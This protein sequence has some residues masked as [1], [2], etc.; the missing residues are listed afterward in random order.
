MHSAVKAAVEAAKRTSESPQSR[1]QPLPDA[2]K[3][4]D[5]KAHKGR[6]A[7][8]EAILFVSREPVPPEQLMNYLQIADVSD[9]EKITDHLEK[10][11]ADDSRGISL[12]RS[13]GGL[14]LA[15]KP[16]M[17]ERLKDFF[18]TKSSSKL[19][20]PSLETLAIVAYRQPVTIAEISDLRGVNST[21]PV[22]KSAA[23]ETGAYH[24]S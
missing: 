7:L 22:K 1:R 12:Q 19:T 3:P 11:Y 20:I 14:Q 9:F 17:H 4:V 24:R 13:G 16:P 10:T 8:V 23:K 15:T 2:V 21:G 5:I 6:V 18:T